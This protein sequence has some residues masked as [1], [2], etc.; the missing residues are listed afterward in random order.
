MKKTYKF[1]F[2]VV[3]LAFA[4]LIPSFSVS[5]APITNSQ[6][7]NGDLLVIGESNIDTLTPIEKTTMTYEEALEILGITPEIAKSEGLSLY[8]ID[9]QPNK[10]SN[11]GISTNQVTIYPGENYAFPTFTFSGRNIGRY[12]TCKGTRVTFGCVYHSAAK[13][14]QLISIYLYKYGRDYTDLSQATIALH[15]SPGDKASL[16]HFIDASKTDYNFVYYNGNQSKVTMIVGVAG[17]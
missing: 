11:L 8:A 2:L 1:R 3:C 10:T 12:W 17:Q 4:L 9:T 15:V 7:S 14:D 13:Q 5:A 6:S 16:G